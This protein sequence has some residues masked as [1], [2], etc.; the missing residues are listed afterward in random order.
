MFWIFHFWFDL[1][2]AHSKD[3]RAYAA[4]NQKT[5]RNTESWNHLYEMKTYIE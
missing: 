4:E 5:F 1:K 3:L 2:C